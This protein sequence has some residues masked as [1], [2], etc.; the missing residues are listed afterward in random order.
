MNLRRKYRDCK[1]KDGNCS[2]C[3]LVRDRHDCHGVFMTKL[4]LERRRRDLSV[5]DL[6][7]A[8]GIPQQRI[9]SYESLDRD[10]NNYTVRALGALA[11]VL[12]VT[13]DELREDGD[14]MKH[15]KSKSDKI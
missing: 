12:G 8:S 3:E 5:L 1:R 6:Q 11:D 13:M 14:V 4:E 2:C 10:P 7:A 9:H 15:A